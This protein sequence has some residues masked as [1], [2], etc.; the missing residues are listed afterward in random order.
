M[1]KAVRSEIQGIIVIA[2]WY[3]H[4]GIYGAFHLQVLQLE[5]QSNSWL[6]ETNI[7][8][9]QDKHHTAERP[10]CVSDSRIQVYGV[11]EFLICQFNHLH[12][13]EEVNVNTVCMVGLHFPLFLPFPDGKSSVK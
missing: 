12:I 9:P 7:F 4:G 6:F 2:K 13:K 3:K 11:F 5:F 1:N 10:L 8:A